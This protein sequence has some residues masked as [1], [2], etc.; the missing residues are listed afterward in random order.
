MAVSSHRAIGAHDSGALTPEPAITSHAS[1][2]TILLIYLLCVFGASCISQAVPVISDIAR[3]FHTTHQQAGWIISLPSALVALG[4]LAVGWIVD[5]V[6]DKATLLSGS[7]L[8]IVGDIGVVL[9]SSLPVL[10]ASRAI[11]GIGYVGVAVATVTMVARITEG[12]RR[13]AALALWSS[14]VPMSFAIPMILASLVAGSENWRW[15]FGGHA[16]ITGVLMIA[17]L[18]LPRW[19]RGPT[20]S[21][22]TGLRAVLRSPAVYALGLSF[23]CGAFVQTGIISTLPHVLTAK[24]AVSFA[25]ASSIGTLGMVSNIA[26]CLSMGRLLNSGYSTVKLAY[27]S[28]AL[29]LA[30]ALVFCLATLPFW[31]A[32][33]AAIMFFYGAGLVVGFWALLPAVAPHPAAR[34]ATS[35]LVTQLTLWGVLFGPPVAFVTLGNA[36]QQAVNAIAAWVACAALLFFVARRVSGEVQLNAGE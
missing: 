26:G 14:F 29:S 2:A 20:V 1:W 11:E 21:R 4:A 32:A 3:F 8:L 28:A 25:L 18:I 10:L 9:A 15:A 16:I 22:T 33:A 6:G 5:R 17:G 34:G 27:A 31:A 12:K 7:L 19:V 13:T 35:G 36:P 24:Y 30:A 23:A